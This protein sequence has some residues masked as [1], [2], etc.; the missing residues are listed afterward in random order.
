MRT[1]SHWK[2]T[3]IL[4]EFLRPLG[5]VYGSITALRLKLTKPKKANIP[6]ICVGNLTAG[7]TGK[8]PVS[9]ALAKLLKRHSAKPFFVT[10]GYG[11]TLNDIIVDKKIHSAVDVGDE[12]LLLNEAAPVVVN[13]NRYLGAIKAQQHGAQY[14][15]MDDGFQNPTLHKDLSLLV[16]DG[17][18]GFGNNFCIPAG[19]LRESKNSGL[20]RADAVI[21]LGQDEHQIA[22]EIKNIPVFHGKIV[23]LKP[24]NTS[25]S[26]IAFAGIGR[27]DKFYNSLKEAGFHLLKK[28]DFPD[29]HFYEEYELNSIITKAQTL[30]AEIYTTAKDYVKIPLA[31]RSHF[32][33]LEI[34]IQWEDE[35]RLESFILSSLPKI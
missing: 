32:K 8:T 19:P 31:L 15:I 25:K 34:E 4:S 28:I 1:P 20:K 24:Q 18:Y 29:H 3:N 10:R 16:I 22:S 30:N 6:V 7:G 13:H 12:P 9:I 17:G 5:W 11:G 14:I 21:I 2:D 27:P 33:V 23:P 35:E 26:I